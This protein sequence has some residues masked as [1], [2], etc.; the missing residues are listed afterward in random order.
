MRRTSNVLQFRTRRRAAQMTRSA[1]E[2]LPDRCS[3]E[4]GV[5]LNSLPNGA[6]APAYVPTI[7][8]SRTELSP[9]SRLRDDRRQVQA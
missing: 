3:N 4:T 8:R 6:A 5:V 9:E 1:F 7:L 2:R